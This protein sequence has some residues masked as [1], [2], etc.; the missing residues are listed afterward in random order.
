[1]AG[2]G[3][4]S[5][6]PYVGV[7]RGGGSFCFDPWALYPHVLTNPNILVAGQVGRGKSAFV[8]TML[9]RGALFGHKAAVLDPKG[10]YRALAEALGC[11]P[12]RLAP[13]GAVRLNPLDSGPGEGDLGGEDITRRRLTLLQAIAAA[14]LRRDL[15]PI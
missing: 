5:N 11:E 3:L 13:G 1:M 8:K 2:R 4:G 10:E 14:T 6:A 9:W 15:T 7:E 12:I